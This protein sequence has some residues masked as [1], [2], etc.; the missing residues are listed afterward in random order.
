[1]VV[2]L[3]AIGF[4]VVSHGLHAVNSGLD[5]YDL[6]GIGMIAGGLLLVAAGLT[7]VAAA[8]RA[9]RRAAAAWRAAHGAGWLV[10]AFAVVLVAL[11][12]PFAWAS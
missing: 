6:T 10:G 8:R 3:L 2:G 7:A 5:R 11:V 9:P 1:M 12:M 4:G